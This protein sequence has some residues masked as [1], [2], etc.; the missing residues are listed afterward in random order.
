MELQ[1]SAEGWRRVRRSSSRC[2]VDTKNK[3]ILGRQD[4]RRLEEEGSRLPQK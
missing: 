4:S 2:K 1:P 3:E